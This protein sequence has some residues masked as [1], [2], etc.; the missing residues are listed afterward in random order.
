M[1]CKSCYVGGQLCP[2][3]YKAGRIKTCRPLIP[4][5]FV[6]NAD[7]RSDNC[8]AEMLRAV[9]EKIYLCLNCPLLE[10]DMVLRS[11]NTTKDFSQDLG[12]HLQE[13]LHAF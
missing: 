12:L 11:L 3:I 4:E 1:V 5:Q 6:L 9:S 13:N 2:T 10:W 7:E 8:N